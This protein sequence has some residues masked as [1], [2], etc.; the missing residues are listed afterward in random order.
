MICIYVR[1]VVLSSGARMKIAFVGKGGSGKSAM[2][3]LFAETLAHSGQHVYVIDAD[4]N[5]D[6]VATFGIHVS[7]TTSTF[8][9]HHT[10]ARTLLN[11]PEGEHWQTLL[12]S[13]SYPPRITL[14]D[15]Y[16]LPLWHQTANPNI[17]VSIVGLGA[18]DI[19]G[20]GKCTHGHSASLKW[21]LP[22]L[23]TKE[24]EVVM[25]DGVAGAD[26]MN[27][28]LYAGCD[29]VLIVAEHHPNSERV[30]L[31]LI[32]IATTTN[33]PYIII[34]NR[35]A[36]HIPNIAATIDSDEGIRLFNFTKV[37][38]KNIDTVQTILKKI[39][40]RPHSSYMKSLQ[41]VTVT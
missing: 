7:P 19:I 40:P 41:T 10:D 38:A 36:P 18:D 29:A 23:Q 4:H 15:S 27:Y 5:M 2:T 32:D 28:G 20:S 12:N 25:I 39:T 26:M 37:D 22:A 14:D 35:T 16:L 30:A 33:I 13:L 34:G 24:N 31:Q 17:K 6:S 21:L 9:R 1:G 3:W 8:H 11:L